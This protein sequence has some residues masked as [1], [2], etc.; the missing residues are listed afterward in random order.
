MPSAQGSVG[1]MASSEQPGPIP[2]PGLLALGLYVLP[3]SRLLAHLPNNC[4][5]LNLQ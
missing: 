5:R 4:A 1:K 2:W 3:R